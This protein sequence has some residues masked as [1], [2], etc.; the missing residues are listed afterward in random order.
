MKWKKILVDNSIEHTPPNR[1]NPETGLIMSI[2]ILVNGP[3]L[4]AP[5]VAANA[6]NFVDVSFLNNVLPSASISNANPSD[7][8]M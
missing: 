3:K 7:R 8:A 6:R 4:A 2:K 5:H 1:Y